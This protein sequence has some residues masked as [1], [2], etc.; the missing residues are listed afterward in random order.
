MSDSI[1]FKV[2][3]WIQV[4]DSDPRRA[5]TCAELVIM[6]GEIPATRLYDAFSRTVT[7][8]A[9]LPLYLMA[10]WFAAN[11]WRLHTEVA[12]ESNN[13]PSIDWRLSHDLAAI[14]GGIIWPRMRFAFDGLSLQ[15]STRCVRNAPWE[16]IRYINDAQSAVKPENLDEAIEGLIGL[17]LRRLADLG[18]SAEPLASIWSYV[19]EERSDP[20]VAEWRQW[21][22]RLG[23]DPDRAP[24]A[25]MEQLEKLFSKAGKFAATE[26]APVLGQRQLLTPQQLTELSAAKGIL[27]T[28]PVVDKHISLTIDAAPWNTGRAMAH[29]VRRDLGKDSGPLSNQDLQNLLGVSDKAFDQVSVPS[30]PIGLGVRVSQKAVTEL[31]FRRRNMPGLRFEAARFLAENMVADE[32]DLWLPLTDFATNRQR[33]QR[34]FAAELLAP[35]EEVREEVG[36]E[37]TSDR[38]EDVAERYG[39]SPLAI[40]SQLANHG[41][42]SPE[43]VAI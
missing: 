30:L 14:G 12:Y 3:D 17:V 42:L 33:F 9:R 13:N 11:W 2:D 4:Q 41:L 16:P 7:D 28:F 19:L 34:A 35:I 5:G 38:F 8:R 10:Q 25:L 36:D 20:D 43:Q 21:E 37:L 32:N 39:V 22:A 23:Y 15:I 27:A 26:I 40:R 24:E 6:L 31:H 1:E 29:R 18:I